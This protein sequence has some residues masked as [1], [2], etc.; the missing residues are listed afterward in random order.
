MRFHIINYLIDIELRQLYRRFEDSLINKF[1]R[2]L[3]KTDYDDLD[4]R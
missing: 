1:V 4:H 2:I 3:K